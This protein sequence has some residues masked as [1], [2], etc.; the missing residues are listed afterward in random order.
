[1]SATIPNLANSGTYWARRNDGQWFYLNHAGTW[2]GFQGPPPNRDAEIAALKELLL[3][4]RGWVDLA[5]D[6][7]RDN[8]RMLASIDAATAPSSTTGEAA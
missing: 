1:M 2:Q 5:G 7:C 8:S 6:M 3:E 4:A